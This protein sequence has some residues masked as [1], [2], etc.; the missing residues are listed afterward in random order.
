MALCACVVFACGCCRCA[1]G[2]SSSPSDDQHVW[3]LGGPSQMG[4]C[5]VSSRDAVW[6]LEAFPFFLTFFLSSFSSF[7]LSSLISPRKILFLF[8]AVRGYS[9]SLCT[10]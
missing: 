3:P 5:W 6:G 1:G 10:N 8:L 7:L 9:T 2:G 4:K